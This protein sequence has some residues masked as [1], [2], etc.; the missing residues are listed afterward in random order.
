MKI[1]FNRKDFYFLKHKYFSKDIE[2][3][4]KKYV[5]DIR[6]KNNIEIDDISSLDYLRQN[7]LLFLNDEF[8]TKKI[9]YENI[10]FITDKKENFISKNFLN[11]ILVKDIDTI[12]GLILNKLFSH[13]DDSSYLDDFNFINNSY[14]SKHSSIHKSSKIFNNCVIGKGVKIGKN[15]IIKNNVVIKNSI[16]KDNVIIGDNSTIGSSGFGFNLKKMG[17]INLFPQLGIVYIDDNVR[18]GSSCTIDRAKIDYTYIGSNSMIDN[19]VHIGHN[20][21]IGKSACIAAQS[22]FSGSVKIGN[23]LIS[24]GQSGYAGHINIGDNVVVAAKSGVTKSI[25]NNSIIAGFPA[26]DIKEWKKK[27]IKDRKNGYK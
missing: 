26:V 4:I 25:K 5:V 10:L 24:G 16:I 1:N 13:D 17:S 2:K 22:G 27:I 3:I 15:C 8:K 14:I 23:N 9:N 21:F 19:L 20:A 7:S 18:I 11:I 6:I 12:Y